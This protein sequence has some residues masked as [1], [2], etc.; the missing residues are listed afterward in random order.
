MNV[1][2]P[3]LLNPTGGSFVS[4]KLLI[5]NLGSNF[6]CQMVFGCEKSAAKKAKND[7]IDTTILPLNNSVFNQISQKTSILDEFSIGMKLLS[8]MK[9]IR[10]FLHAESID[11]VHVNDGL[12][13][14]V[15]G[16]AAKTASIPVI[17]HVRSE[18][19]NEWDPVRVKLCD[20]LIFVAESNKQR[21][22][23]KI[24]FNIPSSVVHNGVDL[25]LFSA[26]E[27]NYIHNELGIN[28]DN[29]VIGFV[30]NLVPRK[31]PMLFV[32]A[33]LEVLEKNESAHF[34]IIGGDKEGYTEE[35]T[36][37][38]KKAGCEN[39]IHILGFRS[40]VHK[41]MPS[42]ALLA[43]TST[44]HG[45]AF[46]RVPI[47]AMA[48]G[49]PVVT[50][51]TAG[52][53]EAVINKETGIVLDT[54]PSDKKFGETIIETLH[55]EDLDCYSRNSVNRA[56]EKFSAQQYAKN[57]EEVYHKIPTENIGFIGR[58]MEKINNILRL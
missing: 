54:D 11:I 29:P 56:H 19:S 24:S 58:K 26:E 25:S 18:R 42:L 30:G 44:K 13:A 2:Y 52:V 8:Y 57:V 27:S 3:F 43:L 41:I 4:T 10:N 50:T 21:F 47:E 34:V 33:A 46:P 15:W 38:I 40:D 17:W 48:C 22:N 39:N 31:R 35:I 36:H 49:T 9:Y 1:C 28:Y 16:I 32:G 37:S 55:H 7:N 51:N 45:E 14:M 6:N 12:T 20:Y 53:S 5:Q 23:R